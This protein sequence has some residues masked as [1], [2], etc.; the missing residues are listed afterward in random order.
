MDAQNWNRRYHEN[1]TP[2][3]IGYA[4]PPVVAYVENTGRKDLP[5]LI[6]GAGKAHEAI[7]LYRRGFR[8]LW[9]CD[10]ADSSFE[11]LRR[12]LPDFP[13]EQMLVQNFFELEMQVD[14]ILEQTFFCAIDPDLR[15]DYAAK[16]AELLKPEGKLAGLLFAQPFDRPGP[17]F[18]GT[19]AEYRGYFTPYF[20]ILHLETAHNSIPPRAGR[21][22]FVEFKKL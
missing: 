11:Y 12:Q 20:E 2:W 19:A 8:N 13:E 9:I 14:L 18:G 17:P 15:P 22:L 4:S 5:I 21:E 16:A 1:Q 7:Y 10:W 3:D 6:P